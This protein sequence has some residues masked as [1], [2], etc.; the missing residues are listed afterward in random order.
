MDE[1]GESESGRLSPSEEERKRFTDLL[2]ESFVE[3]MRFGDSILR[4][5]ELKYG[6]KKNDILRRPESF[7]LGLKDL[8][9]G[10]AAV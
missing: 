9:G 8:M 7:I 1:K 3:C 5:L 10:G 2:I 6:L 4:F